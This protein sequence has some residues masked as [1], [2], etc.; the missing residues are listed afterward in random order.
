MGRNS[1]MPSMIPSRMPWIKLSTR[2]HRL[3]NAHSSHDTGV[4]ALFGIAS[5][6][7]D[8]RPEAGRHEQETDDDHRPV[9]DLGIRRETDAR[10][11]V[12]RQ[13][14]RFETRKGLFD[15]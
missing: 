8:E 4:G 9:T 6:T 12:T 11:H 15:F 1:V 5:G 14:A 7:G 3:F 2:V 10:L 13:H